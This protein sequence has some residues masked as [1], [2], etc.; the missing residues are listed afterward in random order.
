MKTTAGCATRNY[1]KQVYAALVLSLGFAATAVQ[2][3]TA[4]SGS[5]TLTSDYLFRGISQT[6]E[7]MALQGGLTLADDSGFYL[8]TWGSNITFGQGSMELDIL[9]GWSGKL[10]EDWTT[11]VGIMQYRYPNG[12]NETDQFNFV[13]LYSKFIYQ[14][15]TLGLAYS[16]DYFGTDVDKYFYYSADYNYSLV[17][18][19]S[20]Q[21]HLGYN[22]FDN[23]TEYATFLAAGPVSGKGYMD[24]SIGATTDWMGTSLSLKYA[25]TDIDSSAECNLCDGRVVFSL[26]K[27]F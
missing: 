9:A 6:D 19:L 7:G 4:L 16:S 5:L 17:E 14:D 10:S 27:A 24:W 18:N 22:Q 2:A 13:E 23:N 20:L 25:D 11:D 26:T 8:S 21:F 1:S 3:E 12:D 15:L